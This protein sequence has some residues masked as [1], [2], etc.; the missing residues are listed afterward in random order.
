M[1]CNMPI[2]VALDALVD[3]ALFEKRLAIVVDLS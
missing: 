2:V 1:L 3:L